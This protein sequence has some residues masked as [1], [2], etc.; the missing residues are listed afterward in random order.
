MTLSKKLK[1]LRKQNGLSQLL[2]S[3]KLRVSR[4]AVSG[5]E[6]GSSRPS[7]ENLQGLSKLYS[8]PLEYLLDDDADKPELNNK[9]AEEPGEEPASAPAP[10]RKVLKWVLVVLI[11][12]SLMV[13]IYIFVILGSEGD[14]VPMDDIQR[15]AVESEAGPGFDLEW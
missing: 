3:E 15:K 13:V 14:F 5:W 10:K 8:V 4:Q 11:L 1:G 2:L 9:I 12:L 7:T 6:A